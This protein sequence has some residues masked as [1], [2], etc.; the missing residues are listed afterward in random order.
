MPAEFDEATRLTLRGG[1]QEIS[2]GSSRIVSVRESRNVRRSFDGGRA[3]L[4]GDG[5]RV[6]VLAVRPIELRED[7]FDDKTDDTMGLWGVYGTITGGLPKG[8]SLDLY[9]LGYE[10]DDACSRHF[11]RAP[12]IARATL[13]RKARGFRLG[14]R[15]ALS[16]GRV[17]L[18]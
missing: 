8:Q 12:A 14:Y 17:R 1:R 4:T 3:M 2:Y 9:Y 13:C 16:V 18:G 7:V 5:Y 6:D 10:H 11:R 15:G